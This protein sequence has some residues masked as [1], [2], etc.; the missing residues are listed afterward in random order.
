MSVEITLAISIIK[1]DDWVAGLHF[2]KERLG[3]KN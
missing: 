2:I 3:E 1:L